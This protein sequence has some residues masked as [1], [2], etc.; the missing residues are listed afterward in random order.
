[1]ELLKTAGEIPRQIT[2]GIMAT[3]LGGYF[4]RIVEAISGGVF[5]RRLK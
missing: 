1:M 4:A 3:T 5:D 2:R